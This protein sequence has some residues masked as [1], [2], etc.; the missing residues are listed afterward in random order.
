MILGDHKDSKNSLKRRS[1]NALSAAQ[2]RGGGEQE[3]YT[4]DA[5]RDCRENAS[6]NTGAKD[7]RHVCTILH[8]VM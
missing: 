7:K 1:P 4:P 8:N 5:T 3:Q 2:K 6:L